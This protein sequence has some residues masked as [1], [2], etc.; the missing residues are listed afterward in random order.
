MRFLTG[1]DTVV[2]WPAKFVQTKSKSLTGTDTA[3]S[4]LYCYRYRCLVGDPG[5]NTNQLVNIATLFH[6]CPPHCGFYEVLQV[7]HVLSG[8]GHCVLL[9]S[10]TIEARLLSAASRVLRFCSAAATASC[11]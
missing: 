7:L 2:S 11:E 9:V 5:P 8:L 3:N 10:I 4:I 1:T 6:T